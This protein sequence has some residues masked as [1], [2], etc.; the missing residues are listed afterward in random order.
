MTPPAMI[1]TPKSSTIPGISPS[2]SPLPVNQRGSD[3]VPLAIRSVL[4]QNEI[5]KSSPVVDGIETRSSP[6]SN[7]PARP[8]RPGF[9]HPRSWTFPFARPRE[10]FKIAR[11]ASGASPFVSNAKCEV[12]P[13]FG[14]RSR[15]GLEDSIARSSLMIAFLFSRHFARAAG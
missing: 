7:D 3:S 1:D 14:A 9:P 10:S 4:N 11:S 13:L 6:P 12:N 15:S 2:T 8:K 5:V